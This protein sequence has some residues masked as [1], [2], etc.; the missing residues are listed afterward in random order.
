M[1]VAWHVKIEKKNLLQIF[2]VKTT[3]TTATT[4]NTNTATTRGRNGK[5]SSNLVF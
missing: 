3:T 4:N 2:P 1:T 5:S